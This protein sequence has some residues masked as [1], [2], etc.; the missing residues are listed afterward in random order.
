VWDSAKA[1]ANYA[2]HGVR[3][4]DAEVALFDP[5]GLTREDM[6]SQGEQRFVTIGTD[7]TGTVVVAIFA[8]R[9][10][11]IR[12][13]SSRRATKKERGQYEKRIRL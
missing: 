13:I 10:E 1:R 5:F 9:G 7:V 2:E 11:D 8:P 6:S 4:P 12:L 3:L